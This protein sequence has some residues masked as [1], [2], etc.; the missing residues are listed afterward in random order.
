M[1][2]EEN[3]QSLGDYIRMIHQSEC[4]FLN[5]TGLFDGKFEVIPTAGI[6]CDIWMDVNEMN[7]D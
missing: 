7:D 4:D 6:M 1:M 3:K 5:R 2:S